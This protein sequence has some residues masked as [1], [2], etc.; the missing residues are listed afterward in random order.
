MAQMRVFSDLRWKYEN[1]AKPSVKVGIYV[2]NLDERQ[3][4][5][6]MSNS[7]WFD[8]DKTN[9]VV[10][11]REVGRKEGVNLWDGKPND[12]ETMTRYQ[13]GFNGLTDDGMI[14]TW[15][16]THSEGSD[17]FAEIGCVAGAATGTV[18]FGVAPSPVTAFAPATLGHAGNAVGGAVDDVI[19]IEVRV[20]VKLVCLCNYREGR[21][22]LYSTRPLIDKEGS[23][24]ESNNGSWRI[25]P[26]GRP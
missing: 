26:E 10:Y 20:K 9:R 16:L 1:L 18:V 24:A 22:E 15:K 12:S 14:L 4:E 19:S 13:S 25:S 5:V 2:V 11:V 7:Y 8:C 17:G 3:M 23:H 21:Q 6:R